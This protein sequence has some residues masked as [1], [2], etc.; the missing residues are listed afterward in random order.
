MAST[1][2]KHQ[3]SS[4]RTYYLHHDG[5]V[6]KTPSRQHLLRIRAES[7][8]QAALMALALETTLRLAGVYLAFEVA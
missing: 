3:R 7:H 4:E 6:S 2:F 8:Q 5:S 1:A